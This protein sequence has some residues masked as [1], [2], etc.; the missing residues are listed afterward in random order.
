MNVCVKSLKKQCILRN[1]YVTSLLCEGQTVKAGDTLSSR[2][3]SLSRGHTIVMS[4]E[5]TSRE[6]TAGDTLSSRH[7]SLRHAR[8]LARTRT[9][10]QSYRQVTV[11][12]L[13]WITCS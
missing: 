8:G 3:V 11:S 2:H 12:H 10:T 4:R 13:S 7:V 9:H 1:G 5:L 6:L